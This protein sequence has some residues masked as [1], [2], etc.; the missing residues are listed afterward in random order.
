MIM[1]GVVMILRVYAMY[2]QSRILMGILLVIYLTQLVIL[3]VGSGIYSDTNYA[4]S[5]YRIKLIAPSRNSI[6]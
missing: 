5:M 1:I 2:N 4:K 3:I 6:L